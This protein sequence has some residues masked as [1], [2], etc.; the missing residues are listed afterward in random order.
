MCEQ[1]V[2]AP[3]PL[4]AAGE[5]V[6]NNIRT[7]IHTLVEAADG[8]NGLSTFDRNHVQLMG[9]TRNSDPVAWPER[10]PR[11]GDEVRVDPELQ[12]ELLGLFEQL[13]E[14]LPAF[15]G[16]GSQ[17]GSPHWLRLARIKSTYGVEYNIYGGIIV[18][19]DIKTA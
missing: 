12:L 4:A 5:Q 14:L 6:V 9:V 8:L 15:M 3:P 19:R 17:A 2:A 11:M 13:S 16:I 1:A 10:L 18:Y 7:G